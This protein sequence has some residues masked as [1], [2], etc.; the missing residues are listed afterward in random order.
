MTHRN[1]LD[2]SQ[3]YGYFLLS[4]V[5]LAGLYILYLVYKRWRHVRDFQ[6]LEIINA[7]ANNVLSDMKEDNLDSSIH[8]ERD[9]RGVVVEEFEDQML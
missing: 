8:V 3:R 4:L 7:Q 5:I 9:K 6:E 1:L 2:K